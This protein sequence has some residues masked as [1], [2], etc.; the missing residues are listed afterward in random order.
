M[1]ILPFRSLDAMGNE[2]NSV[3]NISMVCFSVKKIVCE[4]KRHMPD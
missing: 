1:V 4:E 2:T 3:M